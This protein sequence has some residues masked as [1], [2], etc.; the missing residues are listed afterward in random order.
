MSTLFPCNFY[1][2]P[3]QTDLP[4]SLTS[5]PPEIF[6]RKHNTRP[7]WLSLGN[8][9]GNDCVWEPSLAERLAQKYPERTNLA[10]TPGGS[11]G[12]GT[13]TVADE[14]MGGV[15]EERE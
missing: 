5:L 7:G 11:S 2:F 3:S 8:Q 6:A 12:P 15:K 9:L 13:G 10:G 4:S 1:L 14:Q